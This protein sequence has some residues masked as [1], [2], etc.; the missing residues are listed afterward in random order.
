MEAKE[1]K[2]FWWKPYVRK[3]FDK[4]VSSACTMQITTAASHLDR[5]TVIL[6]FMVANVAAFCIETID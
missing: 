5:Q 1:V 3:L 4:K 2:E 6:L